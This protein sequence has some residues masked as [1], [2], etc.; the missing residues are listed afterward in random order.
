MNIEV[1]VAVGSD[2]VHM[3][4]ERKADT[5]DPFTTTRGE[6][7]LRN[8]TDAP[9][10]V[11]SVVPN[12]LTDFEELRANAEQLFR[13]ESSLHE[14]GF[15]V[16][17]SVGTAP[18]T[19]AGRFALADANGSFT[20]RQ[21]SYLNGNPTHTFARNWMMDQAGTRENELHLYYELDMG[22]LKPEDVNLTQDV[23]LRVSD[24]VY[25][26]ALVCP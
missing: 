5:R 6:A 25:T 9:V 26:V 4:L 19:Q 16:R 15:T 7:V 22:S 10:K 12:Q 13:D 3:G 18:S 17:P 24:L 21:D 23:D 1:E 8:H 14:V 2:G 20:L 11:V